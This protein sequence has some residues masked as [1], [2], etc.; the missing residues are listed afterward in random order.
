MSPKKSRG[1]ETTLPKVA[2]ENFAPLFLLPSPTKEYEGK[3]GGRE[4]GVKEGRADWRS[5]KN[6]RL[7]LVSPF[8]IPPCLL[9]SLSQP[10]DLGK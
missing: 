1:T 10:A 3:E 5:R 9:L 7:S 8:P 6:G 2:G 4:G